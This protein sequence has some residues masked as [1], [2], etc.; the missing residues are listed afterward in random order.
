MSFKMSNGVSNFPQICAEKSYYVDKTGFLETFLQNHFQ[1]SL[2]L[3]PRRFGK[4]LHMSML[5]SF[6]DCT[7]HDGEKLFAPYKIFQNKELCS[8]W[9]NKYP[10][11]FLNL[12]LINDNTFESTITRLGWEIRNMLLTR[13]AYL[14][15]SE[16]VHTTD[17]KL[18]EEIL[19]GR[20][21]R[22]VL[23]NIL[24]ILC[25]ALYA[26]HREKVIILIDEYDVPLSKAT[27]KKFYKNMASFISFMFSSVLKDNTYLQFA[28]L[29]GCLRLA[30]SSMFT[31]LNNFKSYD[32]S[33]TIYNTAFG[34]TPTEVQEICRLAHANSK[35]DLI[36]LWYDGYR[37][38]NGQ[39]I[40]NPW[41]ICNF[42]ND[43]DINPSASP[44]MYWDESGSTDF[45]REFLEEADS[46]NRTVLSHLVCGGSI[47]VNMNESL[48][49]ANYRDK[50][51]NVWTLL[52]HTGYLTRADVQESGEDVA[53]LTIPNREVRKIFQRRIEDWL[54]SA[55]QGTAADERRQMLDALVHKE[56]ERFASL[57]SKCMMESISY[58]NYNEIFYQAYLA[59][60]I[61][62]PQY[63]V[64]LER[65]AGEGRLDI[66]VK[67]TFDKSLAMV[68][69]IKKAHKTG[70]LAEAVEQALGQIEQNS[71]DFGL[72]AE[73]YKRI[74]HWGIAFCGKHCLA[75]VRESAD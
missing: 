25:N 65:E 49:Y 66:L 59:G 75:G 50:V 38:G 52:Y 33:D 5:D 1:V 44:Q 35:Y 55:A 16:H 17:K 51:E 7:R 57:L 2:F 10:V 15:T 6:F 47:I 63:M 34:F 42:I 28:I 20:Y 43:L 21:R 14:V 18:F 64:C 19:E 30:R 27:S 72:R 45:V 9:M 36:R 4:S 23:E 8:Q 29:T 3:R 73:G 24:R 48:N 37:F 41:D 39:S 53:T 70:K 22:D 71:Y 11:L 61:R 56:P 12:K 67:S 32:I 74:V 58:H 46:D 62:F 31:D 54:G 60:L 13:Y 26:H 69:E 40:Y 68:L